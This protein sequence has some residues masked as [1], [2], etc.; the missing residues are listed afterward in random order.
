MTATATTYTISKHYT[1]HRQHTCAKFDDLDPGLQRRILDQYAYDETAFVDWWDCEL[2]YFC[3][4]TTRKYGLNVDGKKCYFSLYPSSASW[5]L[6]SIEDM[7]KVLDA[8]GI[9]DARER[10]FLKYWEGDAVRFHAEPSSRGTCQHSSIE[11]WPMEEDEVTEPESLQGFTPDEQDALCAR[12]EQLWD[13]LC[14]EIAGELARFMEHEYDYITSE[15]YLR[16]R[17]EENGDI[18][19][20]DTGMVFNIADAENESN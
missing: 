16:E 18:F 4:E 1:V 13:Q 9:T 6:Q 3:D 19:D 11:W 10:A 7:D 15:K 8:L 2:D 20:I 5:T 17:M 14:A 12:V